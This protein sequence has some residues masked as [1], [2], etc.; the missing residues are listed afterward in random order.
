M[1]G[2]TAVRGHL[3][4]MAIFA[5]FNDWNILNG[6]VINGVIDISGISDIFK[7]WNLSMAV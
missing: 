6:R 1:A 3:C 7:N 5:S 4:L 2:I